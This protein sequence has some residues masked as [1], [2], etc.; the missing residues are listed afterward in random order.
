MKQILY[1]I[2]QSK[3]KAYIAKTLQDIQDRVSYL[4]PDEVSILAKLFSILKS[5]SDIP[6]PSFFSLPEAKIISSTDISAAIAVIAEERI[7][8]QQSKELF[9]VAK[10]VQ[11]HGLSEKALKKLNSLGSDSVVNLKPIED[12]FGKAASHYQRLSEIGIGPKFFIPDLDTKIGGMTPGTTTI[13]AAHTSQ[14]KSMAGLNIAY[15]NAMDGRNVIFV[16][17]EVLESDLL[18]NVL[19]GHVYRMRDPK[20]PKIPHNDLRFL[21]LDDSQKE[22]VFTKVTNNL[23]DTMKGRL[24]LVD[25]DHV[26]TYSEQGFSAM[27]RQYNELSLNDTGKPIDLVVIDYLGLLGLSGPKSKSLGEVIDGWSDY[28]LRQSH[29]FAGSDLPCS[30]LLLTQTNREGYK[31]ARKNEGVYDLAALQDSNRQEKDASKVL[32]IY[33]D[34]N[35]K[36]LNQAKICVLKNR[37]GA[38][39]YDPIVV[40]VVPESYIFGVQSNAFSTALEAGDATDLMGGLGSFLDGLKLDL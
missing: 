7:K 4:N 28:F 24:Y 12:T 2:I 38:T 5:G 26:P 10:E 19:S 6:S 15:N 40:E 3:D 37:T 32:T 31:R 35:L 36:L 29:N 27:F 8:S 34:E 39:I 18:W 11:Q 21:K 13:L 30:F 14:F 25:E 23:K 9:D 1:S 22:F 16:S 20:F 33:A 17:L